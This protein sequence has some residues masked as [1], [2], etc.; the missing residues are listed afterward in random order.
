MSN[1]QHRRAQQELNEFHSDPVRMAQAQLDRMWWERR[2]TAVEERRI[3]RD[4]DPYGLGLY[5]DDFHV[6]KRS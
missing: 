2:E 6:I 1:E 5:D 4:L 3:K